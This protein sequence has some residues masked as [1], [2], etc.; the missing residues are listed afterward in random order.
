M[1]DPVL[2]VGADG[3]IGNGL[4][5]RLRACGIPVMGTSRRDETRPGILRFDLSDPPDTWNLPTKISAAVLCAAVTRID[6]CRNDPTGTSRINVDHTLALIDRLS[7]DRV[8]I[9]FPSTNLVFDGSRA[10]PGIDDPVSPITE[11]GRQKAEIERVLATRFDCAAVVRFTKVLGPVNALFEGWRSSLERGETVRPFSD[12]M[13]S[14]VPLSSAITVLTQMVS[15]RMGGIVQVSGERDISYADA[16]RIGV[17][18]VTADSELVKP[19]VAQESGLSVEALPA[20]TTLSTERLRS[21]LG[22]QPPPVEWTL[23]TAFLKPQ[24]LEGL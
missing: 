11:Y 5:K 24:V 10:F 18:A 15:M 21:D 19:I 6:E 20:N 1:I 3:L 9:V 12:M 14:P 22:I 2:I 16:A 7:H 8:F 17:K 4:F 13:F 23:R